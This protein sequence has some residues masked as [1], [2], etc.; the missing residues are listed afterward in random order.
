M[1]IN[2]SSQCNAL[3]VS[4]ESRCLETATSIN[5]LFCSFHSKQCQGLYRG[6]KLRTARLERLDSSVPLYLANTKTSLENESFKD[7]TTEAECKELHDWLWTKYQLLER[8]IRARRLHHSRFFSQNMDYGHAKFLDQLVNQKINITK[9]L[10]RLERRTAEILYK[11]QQWSKKKIRQE[12]QLWQRNWKQAKQRMEEKMRREEKKKQDMFLEKIYKEKMKEVENEKADDEMDWDPIEDELEDGRGS[13]IDL[14]R[15]FL[16]MS[17]EEQKPEEPPSSET[18]QSNEESQESARR[19]SIDE[20]ASLLESST[21]SKKSKKKKKKN[22]AAGATTSPQLTK[23]NKPTPKPQELPDKSLIESRQDM[24]DRLAHGIKIDLND[25]HGVLVAGTV[26]NPNVQKTTRT[27][28]EYEIQRLLNEV[29]EIKH[30]LFCRLLLGHAALLP[31]ALRAD[32]TEAFFEDKEVSSARFERYFFRSEEEE[33][34]EQDDLETQRDDADIHEDLKAKPIDPHDVKMS[35]KRKKRGELPGTWRSKRELSREAAAEN[36]LGQAPGMASSMGSILRG[37]E[38]GAI[39]FGDSTNS[40]QPRRKIRVKVCGRT[41]WN[42]PS[43][44]AM[45]R[46]GWLHFSI[47]AKDSNLNTAIELCRNWNEFFELNILA[48][49]GYFPASNWA[50][51]VGNRL[52]QQA[53]QLG[54]IMYYESSDPDAKDLSVSFSQGGRSKQTRRQHAIFQ[55]RNVICAHIK[56]DDQASRRFIQYLSMQSHRLVL[57]VRDAESGRLLV[58]PPE[59][60][61][62]LWREKSGLGRAVKNVWNV[63]KRIGPEFFEEMDRHRQ[64]NFSFKDYYDVYVWDLEPGDTLAGLFNTVQQ[65]LYRDEDSNYRDVR[66]GDPVQ[67]VNQ[68]DYLQ[69]EESKFFYGD[70]DGPN[71]LP[72]EPTDSWPSNLF[73]NKADALEDEVLFPEERTE[74]ASNALL[75]VGKK[76]SLRAFE[77]E[78]FSIKRFVEGTWNWESEDSETSDDAEDSEYELQSTHESP[79]EDDGNDEWE[80]VDVDNDGEEDDDR[81]EFSKFFPKETLAQ[82]E[83]IR[84]IEKTTSRTFKKAWHTADATPMDMS[85][86]FGKASTVLNFQVMGWLDVTADDVKDAQKALGKVYPFFNPEFLETEEGKEFKD[87]LM[88]N[89]EERAKCYPDIRTDKSTVHHP[90]EFYADLD[91]C[92]KKMRFIDDYTSFPLEW[93]ITI[94][95]IIAKLYKSG[96][97]RSHASR[98]ASCQAFQ[99]TEAIRPSKPDLFVDWR[100]VVDNLEMPE[101]MEDPGKIPPL[102]NIARTFLEF[103]SQR[104]IRLV[105]LMERPLFLSSDGRMFTWLFVPKDLPNS[106]FS[107]HAA[108]KNRIEPFKKQFGSNVVAKRDKYLVMGKDERELAKIAAGVTYAVQMRP[109]RQEVDLWRSFINVDLKFLEGLGERWWE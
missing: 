7:V 92:R 56:R 82:G 26:E 60:E 74:E 81:E 43:D 13:F 16:W 17:S 46:G 101:W 87:S 30:L 6:Y 23:T 76:D 75:A 109:W 44:K 98:E 69:D 73:Y 79:I 8:V 67:F 93:D 14:M 95:P 39:D 99:G 55:A 36:M 22:A 88:F 37:T 80:D 77:E 59:E 63:L 19:N 105:K 58:K 91:K 12:A 29:S 2:T 54:F 4:D 85:D 89:Q 34:E 94:R 53:L 31:A 47:I 84:F 41:I 108:C 48:C 70:I 9:A 21:V 64:W 65:T 78:D 1:D 66:P 72:T 86:F 15:S 25:V 107:M 38:G 3:N 33:T 71:Q 103:Q 49:W 102:I 83:F 50:S 51:W 28:T 24:H 106:E 61:R 68:W 11:N 52:K 45:S 32:S 5:G 57:L 62:W 42:Y 96:I 27:F 10:G 40:R 104:Q 97:I 90:K 100:S 35:L 18:K 20:I